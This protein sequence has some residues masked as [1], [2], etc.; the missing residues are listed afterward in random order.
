MGQSFACLACGKDIRLTAEI[1]SAELE[2][3]QWRKDQS[4]QSD[5][6]VPSARGQDVKTSSTTSAQ[7]HIASS[8]VSTSTA[9]PSPVSHESQNTSAKAPASAPLPAEHEKLP[10]RLEGSKASLSSA[11]TSEAL[12][13]A[14]RLM[15]DYDVLKAEAVLAEALARLEDAN[16]FEALEELRNAP[17]F[18]DVC[19]RVAQYNAACE[20]LSNA[21]MTTLFESEDGKFELNQPSS[22][23]F[24]Y[25]MTVNIDA[26]LSECLSVGAELDLVPKAQP[27]VV[28]V[29]ETI[30]Q[31][32]NFLISTLTKMSV[33]FF[34]VELLFEILRVRN[35]DFG[36]LVES[37]R[38]S[39]PAAGRRIPERGR[40]SIRPWVYT[41]N[42]WMPRGGGQPGTVL[43]QVTRVDCTVSVPQFV[44]NFVFRQLASSFMANLRKSAS[45]ALEEGNPWAQRIVADESGLYRSLRELE[46]V[47]AQRRT[48]AAQTMPG[49]EVFDRPW[50]LQTPKIDTRPPS[51]RGG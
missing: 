25:R 16:S 36:F 29:P 17:V 11:R 22:W 39:F 1:T 24:D 42:F 5:D 4:D 33:F 19:E 32:N 49:K 27:M 48:V 20:M 7:T 2:E 37:I 34:R 26:P 14:A 12:D 41:T 30:G 6:D 18:A 31:F 43:V 50:T 13:E 40:R 44:L 9:S 28:G 23:C 47:A 3:G 8:T 21:N 15:Q 38:S 51:C 10:S 35:H 46:S 45:R